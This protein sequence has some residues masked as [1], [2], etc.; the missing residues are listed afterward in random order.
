ME[1]PDPEPVGPW[2]AMDGMADVEPVAGL[3]AGRL[4]WAAGAT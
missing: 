1:P 3:G 2:A 4:R